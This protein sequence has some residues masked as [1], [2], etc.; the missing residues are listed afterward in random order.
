M[1]SALV[2]ATSQ[3]PLVLTSTSPLLLASSLF[4]L[5][6]KSLTLPPQTLRPKYLVI[7]QSTRKSSQL[8]YMQTAS[9][10]YISGER[11]GGCVRLKDINFV[12]I[13]MIIVCFSGKSSKLRIRKPD[14]IAATSQWHIPSHSLLG[15][16]PIALVRWTLSC[17]L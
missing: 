10:F 15:C 5:N 6:R 1:T 8:T 14:L 9:F 3:Q 13:T 7:S 2:A 16:R 11:A 12:M 4:C 17:D